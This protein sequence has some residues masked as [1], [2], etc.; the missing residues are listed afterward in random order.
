LKGLTRTDIHSG[1]EAFL[2]DGAAD[3]RG[4]TDNADLF[5]F[6]DLLPLL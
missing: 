1:V 4:H 2:L 6:A 3:V 5:V